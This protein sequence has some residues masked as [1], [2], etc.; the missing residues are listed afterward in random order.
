MFKDGV[1]V[2]V[3]PTPFVLFRLG[4]ILVFWMDKKLFMMMDERD[5]V[6]VK[7]DRRIKLNARDDF[8]TS[9]LQS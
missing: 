7:S 9:N 4:K 3:T 6:I 1:V 2:R 5:T 8:A